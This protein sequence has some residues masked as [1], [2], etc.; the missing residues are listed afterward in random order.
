MTGRGRLCGLLMG[1]SLSIAAAAE[2][3]VGQAEAGKATEGKDSAQQVQGGAAE[4]APVLGVLDAPHDYLAQGVESLATSIDRF[5]A[6]TNNYNYT[7]ESFA[8]LRLDS[9]WEKAQKVE[10]QPA[11]R[12]K[13]HLPGTER[14]FRLL[15]ETDPDEL[16]APSERQQDISTPSAEE[17]DYFLSLLWARDSGEGWRAQPAA[18]VV[19]KLPGEAFARLQFFRSF[20]LRPGYSVRPAQVF[21]WYSLRGKGSD[22]SLEFNLRL[23]ANHLFRATTLFRWTERNRFWEP[24]ETLT[25]YQWLSPR[26]R[27]Y[28]QFGVYGQGRPATRVVRYTASLNFRRQLSRDWL[29]YELRPQLS[30]REEDN[31]RPLP[32]FLL[33]FDVIFG[34]RRGL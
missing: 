13:L 9:Y 23:G 3:P 30:Y 19:L 29:F 28:Y 16:L 24:S 8:Q 4:A 2:E 33:R 6:N 27:L 20:L 32:S 10:F 25:L 21:Y 7:T 34:R 11:V 1:L 18:G 26:A 14:R 5:F 17:N 12:A 15:L 22:S 31:W